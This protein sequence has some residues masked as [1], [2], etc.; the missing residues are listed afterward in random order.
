M[1]LRSVALFAG[2]ALIALVAA[3][4]L[5]GCAGVKAPDVQ[6]E[7]ARAS[8]L[9]SAEAIK[10]LDAECARVVRATKDRDLGERCDTF[11]R[12]ARAVLVGAGTIV[13]AWAEGDTRQSITCTVVNV[14]H[15][16]A[17]IAR[18][19]TT[20]GGKELAV[21]GDAIA[22][23]GRLGACELDDLRLESGDGGAG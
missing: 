21:V 15:E 17:L 4:S 13:D 3:L 7:A 12:G 1:S 10:A 9:T 8:L 19:V 6:R 11:Y 16:L 14:A 23:A 22:L 20:K 5:E 2:L 18:E